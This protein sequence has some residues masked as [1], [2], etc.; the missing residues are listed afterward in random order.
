MKTGLGQLLRT[1]RRENEGFEAGFTQ[2]GSDTK[3]AAF[4]GSGTAT[5]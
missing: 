4:V 3:P 5:E 1:Y 2:T